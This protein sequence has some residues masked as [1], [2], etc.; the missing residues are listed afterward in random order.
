ME[1]S[2][3]SGT[4][5]SDAHDAGPVTVAGRTREQQALAELGHTA[6]SH[7]VAWALSAVFLI[8]ILTV[9]IAQAWSALSVARQR[10][11][12]NAAGAQLLVQHAG[13]GAVSSAFDAVRRL[14]DHVP[15]GPEIRRFET[16]M[17][18]RSV[19]GGFVRSWA[20]VVLSSWLG[21]GN[22]N[23]Y[24]GR[25]RWLFYRSGIEYVTGPGFLLP[26]S[27]AE[28]RA[29][30][31]VLEPDPRPSILRFHEQLA[32][33]GIKLVL[34]PTPD[35]IMMHPDRF[36]GGA[37]RAARM[38]QN[39]SFDRFK[40][41]LERNGV[42]VFDP[43]A[44]L[45]AKAADQPLFLSSDTHWTPATAEAV[46]HGLA[47][48]IWSLTGWPAGTPIYHGQPANVFWGLGD[49]A[50]MLRLPVG[51]MFGDPLT[52][53]VR[54]V[55]G[56]GGELWTPTPSAG[57]LLLGDSFCMI[58]ETDP[59]ARPLAAALPQQLSLELQQPIDRICAQGG[60]PY[61]S[62]F[63]LASDLA[64]GTRTLKSVR[65]LVWQFTSRE[66]VAGDWRVIDLPEN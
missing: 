62:R 26:S 7:G 50:I 20:Q 13:L 22:D 8:T 60:G 39:P 4:I 47:Q 61:L 2:I 25:D 34:M 56:A 27:L 1:P 49:L 46:A 17:D 23:A 42:H 19:V 33:R 32:R 44:A 66:L 10:P 36:Y 3:L 41:E 55:V 59:A 54:H 58:Y 53:R 14:L 11:I 57:V 30:G 16:E 6:F 12:T 5:S 45:Y 29:S 37:A 31:V 15:T 35:K 21:I 52:V 9:P 51:R 48:D 38:P 43:S 64:K 24:I 18:Q 40:F 65:V 28:R 63:M